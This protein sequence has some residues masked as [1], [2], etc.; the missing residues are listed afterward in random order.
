MYKYFEFKNK[1]YPTYKWLHD[2]WEKIYLDQ[3]EGYENVSKKIDYLYDG[4]DLLFNFFKLIE[5]KGMLKKPWETEQYSFFN[6]R[7]FKVSFKIDCSFGYVTDDEVNLDIVDWKSGKSKYLDK[8]SIQLPL[9]CLGTRTKFKNKKKYNI[10]AR[11]V[12]P[13]DGTV[14]DY[15]LNKNDI[16]KLKEEFDD[17]IDLY[18]K[19]GDDQTKYIK[20]PGENDEN[21]RFCDFKTI[22]C[23]NG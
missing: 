23:V 16:I 14:F 21:C 19:Y 18:E 4:Y 17:V 13:Q 3:F 20:N 15:I 7:S 10:S 8:E 12:F 11:L 6:Y 2:R 9:Y 1:D 5:E 22:T